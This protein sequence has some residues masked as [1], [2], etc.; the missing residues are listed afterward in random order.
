[1]IPANLWLI[2]GEIFINEATGESIDPSRVTRPV[3]YGRDGNYSSS[4]NGNVLEAQRGVS[5]IQ[6][7]FEVHAEMRAYGLFV[8]G[9]L[10]AMARRLGVPR[11]V[12]GATK[13]EAL[14][15][16]GTSPK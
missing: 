4:L 6:R 10:T 15:D 16:H 8:D 7:A 13:L 11:K 2:D 9:L 3:E 5:P 14:R 12:F 1:M